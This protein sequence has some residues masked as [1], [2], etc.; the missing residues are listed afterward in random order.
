[1]GKW[2]HAHE[3]DDDEARVYVGPEVKLGLSRGRTSYE[4][5]ADGAFTESGPGPTDRTG[6][7]GGAATVDGDTL[8]LKYGDGT[9]RRVRFA[10]AEDRSLRLRR[11]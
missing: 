5:H 8:V 7:R 2:I 11:G 1:M 6:T 4:F 9:E 10:L 3:R